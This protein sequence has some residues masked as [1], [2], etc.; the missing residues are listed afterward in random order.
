MCQQAVQQNLHRAQGA[1]RKDDVSAGLILLLR[2][3]SSLTEQGEQLRSKTV[4]T[5]QKGGASS[6]VLRALEVY[7]AE[8]M[9]THV[10]ASGLG[11][12]V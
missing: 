2:A 10:G 9:A 11:T 6:T 3:A 7:R 1:G 5:G 4:V 8:Q 12:A